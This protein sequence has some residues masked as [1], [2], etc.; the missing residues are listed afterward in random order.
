[1]TLELSIRKS[2]ATLS[3]FSGRLPAPPL[4][5]GRSLVMGQEQ[6]R[7]LLF[8]SLLSMSYAPSFFKL[9]SLTRPC[10]WNYYLTKGCIDGDDNPVLFLAW[11]LVVRL[12]TN[13]ED[14]R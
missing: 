9:I 12:L 14:R 10:I 5:K 11:I 1:M 8:D 13:T 3:V 2:A 7:T 4:V 6:W